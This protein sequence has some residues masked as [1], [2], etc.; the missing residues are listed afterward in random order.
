MMHPGVVRGARFGADERTVVT[1]C[2]DGVAR[3]WEDG[4]VTH[5][6]DAR[7]PIRCVAIAPDGG[8]LLMVSSDG[9][10]V[11][12]STRSQAA[13]TFESA[14]DAHPV[15]AVAVSD[16]AERVAMAGADRV[17]R[18]YDI[19]GALRR[20]FR[21]DA[22]VRALAFSPGGRALYSGGGDG[23]FIGW[24]LGPEE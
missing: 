6:V 18:V 7:R 12:A 17:V 9:T 21:H 5:A 16:D 13:R 2:S 20:E 10:A 23:S 4:T 19:T 24:P 14:L 11:V 1:A 8:H 22:P 3:I 15:W